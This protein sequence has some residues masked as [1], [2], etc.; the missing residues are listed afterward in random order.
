MK[1]KATVKSLFISF[2]AILRNENCL[3]FYGYY[4]QRKSV[5]NNFAI[6]YKKHLVIKYNTCKFVTD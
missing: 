1:G 5:L 2:A 3:F 4:L 6:S